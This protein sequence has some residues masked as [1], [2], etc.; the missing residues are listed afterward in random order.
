MTQV[1]ADL[2]ETYFAWSGPTNA[3]AGTN[4]TAYYRIQG[5]HLVIEYAP[6]HAAPITLHENLKAIYVQLTPA[7]LREI[8]IALSK[9]EVHGGRMNEERMM[10][11]DQ[12]E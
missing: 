4:I 11:V 2:K 1:K 6:A 9:I 3:E 8:E 10:A 12:T 5:P 7:D